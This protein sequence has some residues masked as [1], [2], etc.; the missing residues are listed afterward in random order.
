MKSNHQLQV[1]NPKIEPPVEESRNFLPL[2]RS[3]P[4]NNCGNWENNR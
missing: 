2:H 1:M 4:S 3:V